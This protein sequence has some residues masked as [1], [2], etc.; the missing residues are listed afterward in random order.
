MK[1]KNYENHMAGIIPLSDSKSHH[2]QLWHDTIAPVSKNVSAIQ[3]AVYQCAHAG[4]DTIWI[5]STYEDIGVARKLVGDWVHD[6][7]DYAR[8]S[9]RKDLRKEIPIY[10]V[11]I[12]PYDRNKG[13][14]S[15]SWSILV[16][17]LIAFRV[18][19][20]LSSWFLPNRFFVAFPLGVCDYTSIRKDRIDLKTKKCIIY[21]KDGNSILNN[22]LLPFTLTKLPFI[23]ARRHIRK[24][25]SLDLDKV[26]SCLKDDFTID[27]HDMTWYYD[28]RDW[29]RYTE[30][31][32]TEH[33][34]QIE[35]PEWHKIRFSKHKLWSLNGQHE[36][37]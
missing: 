6:P 27:F 34:K 13:R 35:P 10:Y 32:A 28:I 23:Y 31:L 22:H 20:S 4:C 36:E 2:E 33:S 12:P 17:C 30:F 37:E 8:T 29:D 18:G 21:Q 24:G 16:G 19:A 3:N 5:V 26:F 14:T 15:L 7:S 1:K 25:G 9:G 11:P